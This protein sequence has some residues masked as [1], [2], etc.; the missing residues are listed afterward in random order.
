M[1]VYKSEK[2]LN[3]CGILLLLVILFDSIPLFGKLQTK[4][5]EMELYAQSMGF[6]ADKQIKYKTVLFDD[7]EKL[8]I[9]L[10]TFH[11]QSKPAKR[12]K[13]KSRFKTNERNVYVEDGHLVLDCSKTADIN[14]GTYRKSSGEEA[15][16]EYFAPYIS[17]CDKFAM[18]E[19]RISARIRVS[20]GI[21]DGLFPFCFWTFGQ[22]AEWPYAHEMDIMEASAGVSLEDKTARDGL[23]I[24][25]GSHVSTFATHLHVRTSEKHDLFKEKFM[26]LKWSLYN[27]GIYERSVDYFASIDPTI[28]HIYTVEWNKRNITYF[29]DGNFIT[30]Y[31]AEE[32]G[33]INE[34]GETGFYYPQD[35]RFNIKAGE[36]TSD[37]HGYM[38]VDWVKAEALEI[39]PCKTIWHGDVE[40]VNGGS[41]CIN[42]EFNIGCTNKAFSVKIDDNSIL[43]YKKYSNDASQMVKHRITGKKK[44][45]TKVT[46]SAANG[47]VSTTFNVT[48][49]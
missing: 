45:E 15:P 36:N 11:S 4:N 1:V 22:N 25:A 18:T 39:I 23:L 32:L 6:Q 17:T 43:T 31:D 26:G 28:W 7:F 48:V 42:P 30:S 33:A 24:P 49:E 38:Y 9:D 12:G 16:V 41:I 19:G 37:Q 47:S 46:L 3:G 2:S 34:N 14:D 21:E 10:W 8:D 40:L 29:V 13:Y 35:I 27:R 5:T 44:G 20:K